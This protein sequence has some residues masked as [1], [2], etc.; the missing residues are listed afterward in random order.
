ME[1]KPK[2]I[3]GGASSYPR[4]IDYER[5]AEIA[6][7]CGAYLM[8]DMAHIAG[9]VA[10]KVIPSPIPLRRFCFVLHDQNLLRSTFRHGFL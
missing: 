5:M 1:Y 6:K 9:L 2:L 7:K 8:I 4:L 3:I 10:A